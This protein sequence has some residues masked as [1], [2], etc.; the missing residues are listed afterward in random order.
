MPDR[1]AVRIAYV[2]RV[3]ASTPQMPRSLHLPRRHQQPAHP[4]SGGWP[5]TNSS[6]EATDVPPSLT[7]PQSFVRCPACGQTTASHP[8]LREGLCAVECFHVSDLITA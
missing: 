5:G 2:P 3:M 6:A 8:R 7:P 1:L 4:E